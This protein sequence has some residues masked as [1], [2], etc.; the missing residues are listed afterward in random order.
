MMPP[1]V[2]RAGAAKMLAAVSQSGEIQHPFCFDQ[3][4]LWPQNPASSYERPEDQC[5]KTKLLFPPQLLTISMIEM[6]NR[7][8]VKP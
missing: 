7:A 2:Q 5:E 6:S 3:C 4:I 1:I 8:A